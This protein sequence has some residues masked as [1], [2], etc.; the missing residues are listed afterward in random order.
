MSKRWSI[1]I[2]GGVAVVAVM[3]CVLVLAGPVAGHPAAGIASHRVATAVK[4]LGMA[5][6]P[7]RSEVVPIP[8]G[9]DETSWGYVGALRPGAEALARHALG[10][11]LLAQVRDSAT[12]KVLDLIGLPV[13]PRGFGEFFT[14][15]GPAYPQA[16]QPALLS[17]NYLLADKSADQPVV[18]AAIRA[19]VTAGYMR[20]A[21]W[22][23]Q[24]LLIVT[25][26]DNPLTPLNAG[27]VIVTLMFN[28][29][30]C[31]TLPNGPTV[32][33]YITDTVLETW[34]GATVTGTARGGF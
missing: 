34:P 4:D 6:A 12:G 7:G 18:T 16:K 33:G 25:V 5:N 20:S 23:R 29:G 13:S 11:R 30:P 15:W 28:G 9:Q 3:T 8:C 14:A 10:K 26:S 2:S 19:V 24:Q 27:H 22:A 31:Q 17:C 32:C 1:A 21:A